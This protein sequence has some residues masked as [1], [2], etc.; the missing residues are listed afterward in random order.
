MLLL[1]LIGSAPALAT[2]AAAVKPTVV[3][4]GRHVVASSITAKGRAVFFAIS[5]GPSGMGGIGVHITA[6]VVSDDDGDGR[7]DF[8]TG[9][10]IPFRAVFAVVDYES[11]E[12]T[13]AGPPD[14][15]VIQRQ[16]DPRELK[17]DETNGVAFLTQERARMAIVVVTPGKGAWYQR[18]ALGDRGDAKKDPQHQRLTLAFEEGTSIVPDGK[19]KAPRHLTNGDVLIGID[20]GRLD[21]FA[22]A[23]GK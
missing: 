22:L 4:N 15:E 6:K 12:Y 19:E 8:D 2:P 13:I 11:G 3:I 20:P 16:L 7:I 18:A 1:T 9:Y 5:R 17:R 10:D 21:I 14:Y 23:V